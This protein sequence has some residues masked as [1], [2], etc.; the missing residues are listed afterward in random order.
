MKKQDILNWVNENR[1]QLSLIDS[2][3][4]AAIIIAKNLYDIKNPD[5][6]Q[7][8][9]IVSCMKIENRKLFNEKRALEA[10]KNVIDARQ[11][12][13]SLNP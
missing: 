9:F 6:K 13:R 3:E 2:F 8:R 5:D 11:K 10:F 1:K 4:K 7:I 12:N